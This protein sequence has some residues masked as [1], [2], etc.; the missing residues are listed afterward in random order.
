M[1]R[2][3][4]LHSSGMRRISGP[5]GALTILFALV[6]LFCGNHLYRSTVFFITVLYSRY[7]L[8]SGYQLIV[9][10]NNYDHVYDTVLSI[11][12]FQFDATYIK[13]KFIKLRE[14]YKYSYSYRNNNHWGKTYFSA[15]KVT[16]RQSSI[17]P[18]S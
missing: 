1:Y 5:I 15:N 17:F 10:S 16:S 13:S 12:Y 7:F 9:E 6:Q 14:N 4:F 11:I 3:R 18:C 2:I 8:S